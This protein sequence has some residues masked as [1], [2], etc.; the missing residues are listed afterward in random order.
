MAFGIRSC[1]ALIN[2]EKNRGPKIS[3]MKAVWWIKRDFR[4][5]DNIC[6]SNALE[7]CGEV[8]PFFCWE[9]SIM[10]A[11]DFSG[12]HLQAQFQ[13][14]NGLSDSISKRGGYM[15]IVSGMIIDQFERLFRIYPFKHL[16]S[17]QETGNLISYKRDIEVREWCQQ[18]GV[19]WEE[20]VQSTV[21]RGGDA[22]RGGIKQFIQISGRLLPYLLQIES[23]VLRTKI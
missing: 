1:I 17:H 12:F 14:L 16:F 9:N 4:I 22:N 23:Y 11:G 8:V 10:E 20:S 13:A 6:L 15:R 3:K 18:H 7:K 19:I 5:T 21:L 2:A